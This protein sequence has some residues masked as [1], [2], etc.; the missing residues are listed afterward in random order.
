MVACIHI[1]AR[2]DPGIGSRNPCIPGI[3][4]ASYMLLYISEIHSKDYNLLANIKTHQINRCC[5]LNNFIAYTIRHA[6]YPGPQ[7][8]FEMSSFLYSLALPKSWIHSSAIS[9]TVIEKSNAGTLKNSRGQKH[10]ITAVITRIIMEDNQQLLGSLAE[11]AVM[12]LRCCCSVTSYRVYT[13]P[14]IM[15]VKCIRYTCMCCVY[16]ILYI[17][18]NH[19]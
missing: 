6:C 12:K 14:R 11:F 2:V 17:L 7:I 9:L 15:H 13:L 5:G 8:E 1:I 4:L 3:Y 10:G 16:K 18:H 19:Y